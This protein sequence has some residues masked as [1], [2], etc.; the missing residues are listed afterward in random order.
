MFNNPKIKVAAIFSLFV[1][2]F[3]LSCEKDDPVTTVR[4]SLKIEIKTDATLGDYLITSKGKTLYIFSRDLEGASNCDEDC[5][6][7]WEPVGISSDLP[8]SASNEFGLVRRENG[9]VQLSYK[10]WPL[11]TLSNEAV[12]EITGDN[13]DGEW[14]LA[15]PDYDLFIGLKTV[16]GI[17]RKFLIDQ[18]GQSVYYK[19]NDGVNQSSCLEAAC[20]LK[21]P[22]LK[23]SGSTFPSILDESLIQGLNRMDSIPQSS[24]KNRPLYTH[25][26]DARGQASGQGFLGVWF[27]MEDSF[28]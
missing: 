12:N 28:F 1:F 15:K 27:V 4:E 6:S 23:L 5:L 18:R 13:K 21:Y 17:E 11:Y 22:P 10:G 24:Y 16:D 9:F 25:S 19:S 7:E 20:I 3:I 2:G 14:Y 8:S 26:L